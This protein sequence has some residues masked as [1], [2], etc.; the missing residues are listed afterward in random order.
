MFVQVYSK[1]AKSDVLRVNKFILTIFY[2]MQEK[3]ATSY[4]QRRSKILPLL[5]AKVP[6]IGKSYIFETVTI[7]A[8]IYIVL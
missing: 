7:I 6:D 2:F 1:S 5:D 3:M 8:K 4:Y